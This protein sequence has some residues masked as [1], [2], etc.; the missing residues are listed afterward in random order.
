MRKQR[1]SPAVRSWIGFLVV[2]LGGGFT[3]G[4]TVEHSVIASSATSMGLEISQNPASNWPQVKMGYQRA[5][6]AIV[7]TNRCA[8]PRCNKQPTA[9][10]TQVASKT[11]DRTGAAAHGEVI[12]EVGWGGF[13]KGLFQRLAVG[14]TAVKQRGAAVMFLRDRKGEVSPEA[15]SALKN[16]LRIKETVAPGRAGS[17]SQGAGN[18]GGDTDPLSSISTTVSSPASDAG[19]RPRD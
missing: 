18:A 16:V 9:S 14:E 5:E 19:E 6:H 4:C 1:V 15:A 17:G 2:I 13:C 10:Q 3:A 7:P 11:Q 12:M 8:K